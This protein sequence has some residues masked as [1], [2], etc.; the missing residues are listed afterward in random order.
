MTKPHSILGFV[1]NTDIEWFNFLAQRGCEEIN[2]WQPSGSTEFRAIPPGSPFFFRLKKPYKKIAGFGFLSRHSILP[3]WLAWD[4]F[5]E[6][7]GAPDFETMR[8]RLE[9]YRK[10][11]GPVQGREYRIGCLMILNPTFFSRE[12]WIDEPA[13]FSQNIV[14]GKTYDLGFGEGKRIFDEC[15][16]Q[17]DFIPGIVA[18]PRPRYGEPVLVR[19]RL[20]QCSFRI[21]VI[22]AYQSACAVTTEHSLPVLEA[23]ASHLHAD[24]LM[25]NSRVNPDFGLQTVRWVGGETCSNFHNRL[26]TLLILRIAGC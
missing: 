8:R 3:D 7:N 6:A 1:A 25:R 21:A 22:E 15:L 23:P 14:R 16:K 12:H 26:E 20:G 9:K 17:R 18:N 2:F 11:F 4:T 5:R 13:D 24:K 10:R 19:P